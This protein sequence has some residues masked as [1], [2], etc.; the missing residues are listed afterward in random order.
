MKLKCRL[1]LHDWEHSKDKYGDE[2]RTCNECFRREK[3]CR[4]NDTAF[5]WFKEV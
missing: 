3:L 2:I 4:Y 1:G 5:D